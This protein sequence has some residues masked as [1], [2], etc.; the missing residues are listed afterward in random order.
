[1]YYG[2]GG[3]IEYSE[4]QILQMTGRAGRPQVHSL[5]FLQRVSHKNTQKLYMY[6]HI[7]YNRELL[8]FFF[9]GHLVTPIIESK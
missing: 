3:F 7:H 1:M 2:M 9:V 6:F 5:N 8:Q 4:A